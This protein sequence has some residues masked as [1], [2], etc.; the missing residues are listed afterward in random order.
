MKNFQ[1][2]FWI[3]GL[4][5]LAIY[6]GASMAVLGQFEC[7]PGLTTAPTT[8]ALTSGDPTQTGRV[9]RDGR[10]S[11]CT[12]KTN[13]LQNATPVNQDSYNFTAPISLTP[14]CATL[15][16]NN[17]G[18]ATATAG[19][20]AY[21]TYTPATPNTGIIGDM[22]FSSTGSGSFSFPVTSG[23]S[24]TI[25]VYD[26]IDTPTN[27]FCANYT[28][29]ITYSNSCRQAGYDSNNDGVAEMNYYR[30]STGQWFVYSPA[31]SALVSTNTMGIAGDTPV[32]GDYD[33]NGNSEPAVFRP[34][35]STW[36][37]MN[38]PGNPVTNFSVTQWGI[39]GDIPLPGDYDRD[40]KA[41]INIWRPN[42]GNWYTLRSGTN[43]MS[44]FQWGTLGDVPYTG[45]FDGD[46]INDFGV[47]RI[48]NG[49]QTHLILES[50]FNQGFFL[51]IFFGVPNDLL[52]I[53]DY[54]GDGKSDL[55]VF[56]PSD[57]NWYINQ[58]SV[59]VGNPLL[60]THWGQNGDIPQ[61]ADY[62]GDRKTDI[63]VFRPLGGVWFIARS[64]LGALGY[65]PPA[66]PTDIPASAPYAS[67][68]VS[69][70][71]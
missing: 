7:T 45:D 17:T 20:V 70:T 41:D 3:S 23:Q 62:D 47:T 37:S 29:T 71:R 15:N 64:T 36:Y 40:G 61:P 67:V 58:S 1:F 66:V 46:L 44:V 49:L 32:I 26:I 38:A 52:A 54:D 21:S 8:G 14:M 18:C 11:S 51:Q 35:N 63:A 27:L 28:F 13:T 2:R 19:M 25:A 55:A 31:T 60:V 24:F 57:G 56:R 33:G 48:V 43:T 4:L 65:T 34:S 22:G 5:L 53:G 50:N 59:V 9:V 16:F 10:P 6:L 39:S 69:V 68:P 42:E 12:G 30:P